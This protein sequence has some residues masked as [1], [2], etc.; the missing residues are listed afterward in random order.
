MF[1]RMKKEPYSFQYSAVMRQIISSS[2]GMNQSP[3]E[4]ED[5]KALEPDIIRQVET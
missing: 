1:C 5:G 4:E 2:N 3:R